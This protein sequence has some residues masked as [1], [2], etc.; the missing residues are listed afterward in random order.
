MRSIKFSLYFKKSMRLPLDHNFV[1]E[2]LKVDLVHLTNL[3]VYHVYFQSSM[4]IFEDAAAK[5]GL[6]FLQNTC[7]YLT[8]FFVTRYFDLCDITC[9]VYQALLTFMSNPLLTQNKIYC[10][11]IISVRV[12]Y[13]L[14]GQYC[15]SDVKPQQS[16][17]Q[18]EWSEI[19]K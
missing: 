16:I 14:S 7:S 13:T 11:A 5:G 15:C 3:H 18:S 2:E 1:T 17:N 12:V 6:I 4:A 9:R 10:N 19:R 8:Y